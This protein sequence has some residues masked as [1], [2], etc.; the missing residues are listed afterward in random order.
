M[1][2]LAWLTMIGAAG[3]WTIVAFTRNPRPWR[4]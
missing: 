4:K 1:Q 3:V 2:A